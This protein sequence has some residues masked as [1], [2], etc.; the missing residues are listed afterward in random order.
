M[1]DCVLFNVIEILLEV[2]IILNNF[3]MDLILYEPKITCAKFFNKC[4]Y[5]SHVIFLSYLISSKE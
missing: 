2:I 4:L 3:Y 5:F 1:K